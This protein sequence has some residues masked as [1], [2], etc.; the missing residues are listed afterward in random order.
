MKTEY[1]F[2][3][4]EGDFFKIE[5]DGGYALLMD[6]QKGQACW[7]RYYICTSYID[8][9]KELSFEEVIEKLGK[10]LPSSAITLLMKRNE[11][12]DE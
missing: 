7:K 5:S 11:V 10:Q 2:D 8:C 12:S 4:E 3:E 9:S 6:K 1:Y